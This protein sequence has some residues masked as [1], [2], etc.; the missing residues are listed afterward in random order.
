MIFIQVEEHWLLDERKANKTL[1]AC[2]FQFKKP[3]FVVPAFL[4]SFSRI[5]IIRNKNAKGE[6]LSQTI[7][8]SL[9][10]ESANNQ[11]NKQTKP[12]QT[13]GETFR[14]FVCDFVGLFQRERERETVEYFSKHVSHR[15]MSEFSYYCFEKYWL[16]R[17]TFF[18]GVL[19]VILSGP[20]GCYAY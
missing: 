6:R 2:S 17:R 9:S 1:F 5:T 14:E 16:L 13:N 3:F 4:W 15:T 12:N 7:S 10:K 19:P 11:M 20:G 8:L 18:G